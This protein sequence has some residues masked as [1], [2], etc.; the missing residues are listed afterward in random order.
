MVLYEVSLNMLSLFVLQSILGNKVH[1]KVSCAAYIWLTYITLGPIVFT[2]FGMRYLLS[3][4]QSFTNPTIN[5]KRS[6]FSL[7]NIAITTVLLE[8]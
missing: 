3:F 4:D 5:E 6:S 7:N 8:I 1:V 2:N